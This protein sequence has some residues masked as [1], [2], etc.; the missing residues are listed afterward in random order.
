MARKLP[1]YCIP[2]KSNVRAGHA[3]TAKHRF[4][5]RPQEY[6]SGSGDWLDK[7]AP[8]PM[9]RDW[10]AEEAE[11][12]A[13]SSRE[14][15]LFTAALIRFGPLPEPPAVQYP[16]ALD[17]ISLKEAAQRLGLSPE[18]LRSAIHRGKMTGHKYGRD[19]LVEE[20]E[21]AWYEMRSLGR[22]GRPR[23]TA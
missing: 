23:K 9:Q 1:G 8:R 19:W 20:S 5:T 4:N 14:R 16:S 13:Q 11:A 17:L 12:R 3:A 10:D 22:R 2:C 7:P 18:T 15:E 21:V 6:R